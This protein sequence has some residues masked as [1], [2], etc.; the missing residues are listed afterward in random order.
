MVVQ[1]PLKG[2]LWKYE[3][4]GIEDEVEGVVVYLFAFVRGEITNNLS[5]NQRCLDN[6][7]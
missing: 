6:G 3:Q 7:N 2:W 5:S 4:R 1:W